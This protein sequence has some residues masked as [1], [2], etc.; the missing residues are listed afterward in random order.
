MRKPDS[1]GC[2][3]EVKCT[4]LPQPNDE[5]TEA[6]KGTVVRLYGKMAI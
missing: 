1:R 5:Q 3:E 4:C 2:Y 6:F